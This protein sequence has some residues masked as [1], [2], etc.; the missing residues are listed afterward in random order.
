MVTSK[1]NHMIPAKMECVIF[2]LSKALNQEFVLPLNQKHQ[3][4]VGDS[5]A[6]QI[7]PLQS[8]L[9]SVPHGLQFVL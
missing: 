9:G 5:R 6:R 7:D 2:F 4:V 8:R 3:P 1:M